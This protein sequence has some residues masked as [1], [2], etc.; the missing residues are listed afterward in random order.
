MFIQKIAAIL[1]QQS[2]IRR[3]VTTHWSYFSSEIKVGIGS[4]IPTARCINKSDIS[5][6]RTLFERI[7]SY[8]G[9]VG[10]N[11]YA[12]GEAAASIERIISYL[13]HAGRNRYAC[14]SAAS[15]ERR[16]SY[17]SHAGGN[18]YAC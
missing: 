15:I 8:L 9:H 14:E 10:R 4:L 2:S 16:V 18:R 13:C 7:L 12:A 11:R 3:S 17:R 5:K 1:P 6:F